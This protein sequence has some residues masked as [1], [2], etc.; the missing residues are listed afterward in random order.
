[1]SPQVSTSTRVA[2]RRGGLITNACIVFSAL[3][4][5]G[6]GCEVEGEELPKA[7][8]AEPELY[9]VA[10]ITSVALRR[11]YTISNIDEAYMVRTVL[12]APPAR[13]AVNT[14]LDR[15]MSSMWCR[16]YKGA[17]TLRPRLWFGSTACASGTASCTHSTAM[18]VRL[19][20]WTMGMSLA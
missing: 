15:C 19:F 20:A 18:Y 5:A 3:C 1:M 12:P 13:M 17:P 7:K 4:P 16:S 9:T 11:G 8:E 10:S 14:M 2:P 6:G